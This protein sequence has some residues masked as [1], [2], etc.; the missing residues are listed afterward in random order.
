MAGIDDVPL[1]TWMPPDRD[2]NHGDADLYDEATCSF[3][4]GLGVDGLTRPFVSLDGRTA[5]QLRRL[6]L[7]VWSAR[8]T[9]ALMVTHNLTEARAGPRCVYVS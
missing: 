3:P 6:L 4:D 5:E 9:T 7:D 8:P 2:S 1:R